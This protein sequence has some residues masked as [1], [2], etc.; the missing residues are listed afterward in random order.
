MEEF[1]KARNKEAEKSFLRGAAPGDAC[2]CKTKILPGEVLERRCCASCLKF[3]GAVCVLAAIC[4]DEKISGFLR[5][6][7]RKEYFFAG[8]FPESK[9][10]DEETCLC[11]KS[12][13]IEIK[14]D[15]RMEMKGCFFN[16]YKIIG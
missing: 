3:R 12:Y 11:E 5:A 10:D 6:K 16:I 1:R 15:R 2:R 7:V 8:F 9:K 14:M 13:S 4:Q